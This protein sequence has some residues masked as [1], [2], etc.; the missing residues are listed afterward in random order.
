MKDRTLNDFSARALN[1]NSALLNT[2]TRN[3]LREDIGTLRNRF[4]A[5]GEVNKDEFDTYRFQLRQTATIKVSLENE[6]NLGF[7][8]VFGT[9]K[10]VQ[11]KLLNGNGSTLRSTDRV[12]PEGEDD[13]RI[14]LRAGTYSIRVT[15][16][17]EKDV[18]YELELA[19]SNRNSDD[20]DDFDDDFDDN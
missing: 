18:E 2:R 13:F 19:R 8:D 6:E 9:K 1:R 4:R 15:G 14:R 7:F 3:R 11:A 10:R 17:S 16:R 5:S 12:R 20:D